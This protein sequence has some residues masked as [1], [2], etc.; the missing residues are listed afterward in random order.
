MY[1][2]NGFSFDSSHSKFNASAINAHTHTVTKLMCNCIQHNY[3]SKHS[4]QSEW[5]FISSFFCFV[6]V[7]LYEWFFN[8]ILMPV[9]C[10][11]I[12]CA[13]VWIYHFIVAIAQNLYWFFLL[14][15][16]S[17]DMC[18][19]IRL[20][21]VSTMENNR[22]CEF[23]QRN[24]RERT[25]VR[26]RE[27]KSKIDKRRYNSLLW[28]SICERIPTGLRSSSHMFMFMFMLIYS[29][30]IV[31]PLNFVHHLLLPKIIL[32]QQQQN[33]LNLFHCV[34]SIFS[35]SILLFS[36]FFRFVFLLK[37]ATYS[38]IT[39][40][41][42]PPLFLV[43]HRCCCCFFAWSKCIIYDFYRLKSTYICVRRIVFSSLFF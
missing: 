43:H 41:S 25:S 14:L 11:L 21:I 32:K 13:Y 16:V 23:D 12:C 22:W 8:F 4:K 42:F 7:S 35:S 40:T 2:H 3:P 36:R 38:F 6:C 17:D 9:R 20:L 29:L 30:N 34:L 19:M 10:V 28:L 37:T 26:A 15:L 5:V 24:A 1:R 31:L 27:L 39:I 33:S 18:Y